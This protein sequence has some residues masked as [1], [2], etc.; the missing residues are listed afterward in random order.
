MLPSPPFSH[1]TN[2]VVKRITQLFLYAFSIETI[3]LIIALMW[4]KNKE[5]NLITTV[6]RPHLSQ[7][8]ILWHLKGEKQENISSV[9]MDSVIRGKH[10]TQ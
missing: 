2:T 8:I 10:I 6:L 3:L 5:W 9:Y 7:L 4:K 1:I